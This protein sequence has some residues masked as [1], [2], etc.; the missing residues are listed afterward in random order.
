MAKFG[1]LL[2]N[3]NKLKV[4]HS[5]LSKPHEYHEIYL[6]EERAPSFI[7]LDTW[8]HGDE[9]IES[10]YNMGLWFYLPKA[11]KIVLVGIH[12]CMACFTMPQ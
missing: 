10:W 12:N 11:C 7:Q 6:I 1:S 9:K 4:T 2:A 5:K 8:K 3:E